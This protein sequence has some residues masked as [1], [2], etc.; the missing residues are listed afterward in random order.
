[1]LSRYVF[2]LSISFSLMPILSAHAQVSIARTGQSVC[3]DTQGAVIACALTG[4]D[5]D[6]MAGAAWP[7]PRFSPRDDGTVLDNLTGLIWLKNPSCFPAQSWTDAMGAVATLAAGQ[8][9]LNDGSKASDWHLPNIV[10]LQSLTNLQRYPMTSW[11]DSSG[12]TGIAALTSTLP[13]QLRKASPSAAS[14]A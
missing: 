9:G 4:Q 12:F 2:L 14:A 10:E 6:I 1:M 5:G 11:L 13:G 7:S 8:C 3:Y